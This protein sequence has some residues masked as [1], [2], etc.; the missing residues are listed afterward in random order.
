MTAHVN[1]KPMELPGELTIAGLVERLGLGKSRVAVEVNKG[2]VVRK[3]WEST[4]LKEGD[5]IEVV[6]FVGGG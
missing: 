2:L 6:T 5:R 4:R 1:G 3:Q